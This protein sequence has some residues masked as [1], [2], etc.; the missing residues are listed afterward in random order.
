[1]VITSS[2]KKIADFLNSFDPFCHRP[3]RGATASRCQADE[4]ETE[5]SDDPRQNC[6]YALQQLEEQC[7]LYNFRRRL[8]CFRCG[9]AK[10]GIFYFLM[11]IVS[12]PFLWPAQPL[13]LLSGPQANNYEQPTKDGLNSDNIGNKMLQAMGWKEG[14]G[15]GRNQQGITAPIEVLEQLLEKI[16]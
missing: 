2:I 11:A 5:T 16:F 3:A 10:A 8:K 12:V 13:L 1:E 15:L 6:R 14:K 9:A 7:G 4:K